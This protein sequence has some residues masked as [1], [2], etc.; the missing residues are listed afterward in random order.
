MTGPDIS[1]APRRG[2]GN[3]SMIFYRRG[4]GD[5]AGQETVRER[6]AERGARRSGERG[7]RRSGER[8]G[9]R[10]EAGEAR[11]SGER[12]G[13]GSEAQRGARQ[14]GERGGAGSGGDAGEP[15]EAGVVW[16]GRRAGTFGGLVVVTMF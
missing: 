3:N 11:R 15:R 5:K 1:G 12:D 16:P 6:K 14:S 9:A 13:A 4:V 8:G 10:G 7:A 2:T